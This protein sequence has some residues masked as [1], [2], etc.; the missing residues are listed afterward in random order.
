MEV[1]RFSF[2]FG[3]GGSAE[4]GGR[5]ERFLDELADDDDE[6]ADAD[7]DDLAEWTRC[8]FVGGC[9]S[10]CIAFSRR[11]AD[12]V[13]AS[14]GVSRDIVGDGV[15]VDVDERAAI[16]RP[17]AN[18]EVLVAFCSTSNRCMS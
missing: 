15:D 17:Y 16:V 8:F 1:A 3:G 2:F 10:G 11:K 5:T 6:L 7:D 18:A 9:S 4:C 12:V 13:A 14:V